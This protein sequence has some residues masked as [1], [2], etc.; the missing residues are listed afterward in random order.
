MP[1]SSWALSF[2]LLLGT[3]G[4]A[5]AQE[6]TERFK[7][8]TQL[9]VQAVNAR[10]DAAIRREF[11]EEML[12]ALPSDV[13]KQFFTKVV[14]Q[15]GKIEKVDSPRHT[16]P[17][18]AVVLA[19]CESGDL[20]VTVMLDE[21]GKIAGLSLLPPT[22]AIPVPDRLAT[23]FRLPFE[24]RWL[25]LWGGDSKE[26]NRHHDQRYQRFAFDFVVVDDGGRSHRGEGKENKDFYAFGQPILAPADGVVTDVVT[27]VRDNTPGCTNPAF[28]G[29]N[30]V[31]L[32]HKDY[33]Y[34]VLG[35]M[36]QGSIR[37]RCG[38]NV[39]QGQVLGLCGNSGNSSEPHI[40]FHVQNTPI[41]ADATGL[42]CT[43]DD[44]TVMRNGKGEWEV[45][46]SP[47]KGDI[48]RQESSY[49]GRSRPGAQ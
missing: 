11:S 38:D 30:T 29:G 3:A 26:L 5:V 42:R 24:G 34:S 17:N 49:R 27:G 43:F 28:S 16:A 46:G 15:F 48:V 45:G 47:V 44:I 39:K 36:Q 10:D 23:S 18:R 6:S 31:I 33:E 1:R 2:S 8:V 22:R 19:H 14:N 37:V 7:E 13:A 40:H 20:E 12:K 9:L 4:I 25:V 21:H 35:H 41:I 32:M